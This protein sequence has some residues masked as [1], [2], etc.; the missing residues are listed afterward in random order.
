MSEAGTTPGRQAK[1]FLG[2]PIHQEP[3][4]VN[5]GTLNVDSMRNIDGLSAAVREHGPFAALAIQEANSDDRLERFAAALDMRVGVACKAD[6]GFINALLVPQDLV[7]R[8][9]LSSPTYVPPHERSRDTLGLDATPAL[10]CEMEPEPEP[11]PASPTMMLEPKT[12]N[13]KLDDGEME[14]RAACALSLSWN[15]ASRC[16]PRLTTVVCTHLDAYQESTRL[17]QLRQLRSHLATSLQKADETQQEPMF[18][19]GDFNALRRRDYSD[20]EWE[21]LCE[22]RAK[23][24]VKSETAVTDTLEAGPTEEEAGPWGLTDCATAAAENRTGPIA[25]SVYGA[26]VDYIWANHAA[27]QLWQVIRYVHVDMPCGEGAQALTDH[28]LVVCELEL[29]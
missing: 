17:T 2:L 8:Q 6:F 18:L 3:V 7:E 12:M 28:S 19:L 13:C 9:I 14:V 11:E 27:M 29:R 20:D 21:A 5:L 16:C 15:G 4:R 22:Q 24:M 23:A 25:S 1:Y 10:A 26:R